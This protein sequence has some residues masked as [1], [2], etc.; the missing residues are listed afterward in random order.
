MKADVC[1]DNTAPGNEAIQLCDPDND[2]SWCC[3]GDRVS[4]DCCSMD[5]QDRFFS[6]TQGTAFATI[7]SQGNQG[8]PASR[9]TS[10]TSTTSSD[11][12]AAGDADR[13]SELTACR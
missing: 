12:K 6:L 7:T 9:T 2:S 1:I 5:D 8:S 3:D 13:R 10:S 11:G 4:F